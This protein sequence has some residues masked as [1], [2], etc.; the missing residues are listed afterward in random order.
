MLVMWVGGLLATLLVAVV[1]GSGIAAQRLSPGDV[2]LQLLENAI[3]TAAGLV[4]IILAVGPVSTV[5]LDKFVFAGDSTYQQATV[6]LFADMGVQPFALLPELG[7]SAASKSTDTTAPT[8]TITSPAIGASL[9][10]GALL[11]GPDWRAIGAEDQAKGYLVMTGASEFIRT[12]GSRGLAR[13]LS[14][15]GLGALGVSFGPGGKRSGHPG[16]DERCSGSWPRR[17]QSLRGATRPGGHIIAG[18]STPPA[19]W[20][21]RSPIRR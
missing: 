17:R 21:R 13:I 9:Q 8:A 10:D 18:C 14:A 16:C 5:T 4:A 2:G 15:D 3:A 12:D 1:V 11:K 7:L 20:K 19:R 6:N